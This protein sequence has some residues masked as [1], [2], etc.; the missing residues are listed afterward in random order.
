[1]SGQAAESSGIVQLLIEADKELKSL[2]ARDAS[3]STPLQIAAQFARKDVVEALLLAYMEADKSGHEQ[4]TVAEVRRQLPLHRALQRY[5]SDVP[6]NTVSAFAA[7]TLSS[8]ETLL[9]T[10]DRRGRLPLHLACQYGA[11]RSVFDDLINNDDTGRTFNTSDV[12]HQTPSDVLIS[13]ILN[14][15]PR[16]LSTLR[17]MADADESRRFFGCVDVNGRTMLDKLIGNFPS[18]KAVGPTKLQKDAILSL[19]ALTPPGF[20]RYAASLKRCR[21]ILDS[22][23]F[24]RVYKDPRFHRTLNNLMCKRAFTFYFMMDLYV[25]VLLVVFYAIGSN[26]A[27]SGSG[28]SVGYFITLYLCSSYLL[29]WQVRL[30]WHHQLYYLSEFWNL[31]DLVTN[32]LVLVSVGLLQSR[33]PNEGGYRVLNVIVGGLVWFVILAVALRSTFKHFSVFLNGLVVVRACRTD[34]TT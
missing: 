7:G 18:D 25:R 26:Y 2:G 30:A 15:E 27:I 33:K 19:I 13:R 28:A 23:T 16:S 4:A 32:L 29:L 8:S 3:G 31:L 5:P 20:G 17:D 24:D 34:Q 12:N 10:K 11:G 22:R 14:E 9:T 6:I 1:L 21:E